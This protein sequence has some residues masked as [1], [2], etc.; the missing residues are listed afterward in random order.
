M[1][2]DISKILKGWDFDADEVSVRVVHGDDG[3]EK[4]QL[5]LDMGL[6]QMEMDGRPDGQRPEGYE[7]WLE[8]YQGKQRQHDEQNLDDPP[9]ELDDGDCS[10]LWREAVQYYHRYL[11]FWHLDRYDLCARD[12]QRNLRLFAFAKQ[13]AKGERNKFQFDQWRPY[14]TMM[15]A[16]AVATPL[17]GEKEYGRALHVIEAGIDGIKDFL[18]EYGQTERADECVE[19]AHLERWRDEVLR[20]AARS[21]RGRPEHVLEGLRRQLQE[22]VAR[23]RFEEAAQLRDQIRRLT[24]PS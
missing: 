3:R 22:A 8:Y 14:V 11:S 17:V 19:L 9:F 23:E 15:S 10:R 21:G 2:K 18:D 12:T 5:R 24:E 16:R 20:K 1:S 7:S 6:L 4:I 13:Y